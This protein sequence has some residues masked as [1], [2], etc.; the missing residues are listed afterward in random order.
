MHEGYIESIH[1]NIWTKNKKEIS[2]SVRR[3]S[4]FDDIMQQWRKLEDGEWNVVTIYENVIPHQ[5]A[6]NVLTFY[7]S[8]KS[9]ETVK[10]FIL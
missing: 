1:C 6:K 5:W 3:I 2:Y 9:I 8:K 7:P 4:T 10:N